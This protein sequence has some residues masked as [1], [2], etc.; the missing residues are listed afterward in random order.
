[1]SGFQQSR[2]NVAAHGAK[3]GYTNMHVSSHKALPLTIG[4]C[5]AP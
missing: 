1:M 5:R 3:T 2:G 4:D